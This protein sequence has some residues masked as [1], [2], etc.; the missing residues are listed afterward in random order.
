MLFVLCFQTG[1]GSSDDRLQG[2]RRH[3]QRKRHEGPHV[4]GI[5][6]CRV[7]TLNFQPEYRP[8]LDLVVCHQ[9]LEQAH[10]DLL[11][12]GYRRDAVAI[13]KQRADVYMR[14]A[15]R[16]LT[17]L[18]AKHDFMLRAFGVLRGAIDVSE[19]LLTEVQTLAPVMETRQ[20]SLPVERECAQLKLDCC[21]VMLEMFQQHMDEKR[22]K[23]IQKLNKS[24]VVRVS[25]A[26]VSNL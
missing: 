7:S 10:D 23:Q 12:L 1:R 20:M 8:S 22:I 4:G 9:K 24:A 14:I 6:A 18:S 5:G 2:A 19:L 11:A 26:D 16:H 15:R 25:H 3:L 13:M 17:D 21:D